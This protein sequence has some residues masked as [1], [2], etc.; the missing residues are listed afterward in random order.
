MTN[1]DKPLPEPLSMVQ[2]M[3][4][5]SLSQAILWTNDDLDGLVQDLSK[6]SALT[7]VLLQSCAK[8]STY[9]E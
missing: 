6:S 4:C 3:A 9:C 7:M 2:V 8:L 1:Y 5:C